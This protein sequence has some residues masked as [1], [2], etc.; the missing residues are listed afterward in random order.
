M[1]TGR[2]PTGHIERITT[3]QSAYNVQLHPRDFKS[4][5]KN[6]FPIVIAYN[7]RDHFVPTIATSENDFLNWK[8]HK[9]FGSLLAATLLIGKECDRPGVP[10]GTAA[11]IRAVTKCLETHLPKI[12]KSSH[13]YYL[14][15]RGRS[16]KTHRGPGVDPSTGPIPSTSTF[17]SHPPQPPAPSSTSSTCVQSQPIPD[18]AAGAEEQEEEP[19]R[20]YKCQHCGVV[21]GRKPDLRGHLWT[22]HGL[23]TP[24]VCNLGNCKNKSFS[25]DSSLKQHIRTQH[26]G[27]YK[28]SCDRCQFKT[29]NEQALVSHIYQ[30]HHI[31]P[32]DKKG[33]KIIFRC[34]LCGKQFIGKHLLTKHQ[35]GE[36]CIK[37]KTIKCQHCTRKFK[38]QDGLGY[39]MDHFHKGKRSPCPKCGVLLPEKSIRN[40]LR[41][42]S[43]QQLVAEARR[44]H[45]K[46]ATRERYFAYTSRRFSRIPSTKSAPAKLIRRFKSPRGSPKKKPKTGK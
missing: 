39:H 20:G 3:T 31:V 34:Q 40:H 28:F 42:H 29:D 16:A 19:I 26:R 6:C 38:S 9:E 44:F 23:G 13:T 11:S 21:K 46:L 14:Q 43:A 25:C 33:K 2:Q 7:G 32:K 27:E 8:I 37:K 10:A 12:S 18:P 36:L 35:K 4:L 41:R 22:A 30:T 24:I 15:L 1:S 17:S 45:A 5:T